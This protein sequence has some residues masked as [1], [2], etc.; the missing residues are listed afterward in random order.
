MLMSSRPFGLLSLRHTSLNRVASLLVRRLSG[1]QSYAHFAITIIGISV[2][3][4]SDYPLESVV[5]FIV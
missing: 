5:I 2:S 4:I 1:L 3:K